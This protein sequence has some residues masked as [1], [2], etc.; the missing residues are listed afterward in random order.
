[1]MGKAATFVELKENQTSIIDMLV[2]GIIQDIHK[3]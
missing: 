1:M 3:N 2:T